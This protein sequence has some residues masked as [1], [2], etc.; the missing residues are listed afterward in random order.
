MPAGS[1]LRGAWSIGTTG[2]DVNNSSASVSY[3]LKYPGTT[4]PTLVYVAAALE[5]CSTSPTKALCEANNKNVEDGACPGSAENPQAKA[6]FVCFYVGLNSNA[7]ES[8][9]DAFFSTFNTSLYGATLV[10]KGKQAGEKFAQFF[11]VGTW[12]VTAPE[13]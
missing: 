10:M 9:F 7:G 13:A 4:A 2:S 3:L 6:G 5:D 8:S 12:A 1:T 11:A